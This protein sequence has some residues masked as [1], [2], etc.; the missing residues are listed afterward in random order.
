MKVSKSPQK[1]RTDNCNN[2]SIIWFP[3]RIMYDK[4]VLYKFDIEI[5]PLANINLEHVTKLHMIQAYSRVKPNKIVKWQWAK[6]SRTFEDPT[7][8]D[9]LTQRAQLTRWIYNSGW[10]TNILD[11]VHCWTRTIHTPSECRRSSTELP[12]KRQQRTPLLRLHLI[13][14]LRISQPDQKSSADATDSQNHHRTS[15][16]KPILEKRTRTYDYLSVISHFTDDQHCWSE[17]WRH[18]IIMQILNNC[19][20]ENDKRYSRRRFH[21]CSALEVV[22]RGFYLFATITR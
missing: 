3:N 16:W 10:P 6:C 18:S 22:D 1:L 8:I 11:I 4:I 5:A 7:K 15:T 12:T 21:H 9:Y 19:W 13:L 14:Q 2:D 20:M 17:F